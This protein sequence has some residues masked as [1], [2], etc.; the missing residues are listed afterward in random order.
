M[1]EIPP[2]S[3]DTIPPEPGEDFRHGS[4]LPPFASEQR[5]LDLESKHTEVMTT[6][7]EIR[8]LMSTL[9]ERVSAFH[10]DIQKLNT[11]MNKLAARVAML[12]GKKEGHN[13]HGPNG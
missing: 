3:R 7:G 1:N 13:G 10:E 6:L 11:R 12:D 8:K 5:V 4:T 9:L 2:T